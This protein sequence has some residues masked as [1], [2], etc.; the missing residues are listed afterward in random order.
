MCGHKDRVL[1]SMLDCTRVKTVERVIETPKTR[2]KSWQAVLCAEMD[3]HVWQWIHLQ[4]S[5]GHVYCD[6]YDDNFVDIPI[7][8]PLLGRCSCKAGSWTDLRF[9]CRRHGLPR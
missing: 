1:F 3:V 4:R 9:K 7:L 5:F 6:L 8:S 2:T